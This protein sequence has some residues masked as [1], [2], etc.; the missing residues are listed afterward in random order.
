VK[1]A[2]SGRTVVV[3]LPSQRPR[4]AIEWPQSCER[5]WAG[6]LQR[7]TSYAENKEGEA[8]RRRR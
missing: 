6:S 5:F 8:R 3:P 4:E 2:K 7:L 1:R